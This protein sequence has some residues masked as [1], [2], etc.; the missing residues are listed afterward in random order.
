ME[1][2]PKKCPQPRG[3]RFHRPRAPR[4]GRVSIATK[5]IG[6]THAAAHRGRGR[7]RPAAG[8]P[9]APDERAQ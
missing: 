9:A 2:G 6:V 3:G 7:S 4:E 5:V 8:L 1:V